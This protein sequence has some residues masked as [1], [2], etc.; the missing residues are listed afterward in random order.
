MYVDATG[1]AEVAAAANPV[2][3]AVPPPPPGLPCTCVDAP[4]TVLCGSTNDRMDPIRLLMAFSAWEVSA[5]TSVC[6]SRSTS[7]SWAM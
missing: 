4:S 2:T 5:V 1:T 3:P 6:T 7:P